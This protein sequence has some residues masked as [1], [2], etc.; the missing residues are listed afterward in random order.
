MAQYWDEKLSHIVNIADLP[1]PELIRAYKAG[2]IYTLIVKDGDELKIGEE[3]YED[4]VFEND[5]AEILATLLTIGDPDG[6]RYLNAFPT[7][8]WT[9]IGY[10]AKWKYPWLWAIYLAK[11][12]NATGAVREH[13]PQIQ[14]L[15][16]EIH[17]QDRC[18][19]TAECSAAPPTLPNP[20]RLIKPRY[21]LE[22]P[23]DS[24]A[25]PPAKEYWAMDNWAALTGLASYKYVCERLSN[26]LRCVDVASGRDERKW[27][28]SEYIDLLDALSTV[29]A[30]TMQ[31]LNLNYLPVDMYFSNASPILYGPGDAN[32]A[33]T[34]SFGHWAWDAY[35]LGVLPQDGV[36]LGMIDPTYISRFQAGGLECDNFGAFN[37]IGYSSAYNAGYGNA[38]LRGEAYRSEGISAYQFMLKNG[39]SGP[40]SWWESFTHATVNNTP[41]IGTHPGG[42]VSPAFSC[43]HITG[44]A[45]ATKVLVDS[46]IALK[47]DGSVIIGRGVPNAWVTQMLTQEKAIK[48]LNFPILN[49]K[50]MGFS[51]TGIPPKQIRLKLEDPNPDG[52]TILDLQALK[53]NI[54][55]VTA[56]TPNPYEGTI[57]LPPGTRTTTVTL[58][59]ANP[60]PMPTP[61][62]I[63][64][65][66]P[67]STIPT[68]MSTFTLPVLTIT[69]DSADDLVGFQGDLTFDPSVVTF[70][71]T[72]VQ[73]AGLTASKWHVSGNVMGTG[74]NR[75]LHIVAYSPK[76]TPLSGSGTLFELRMKRVSNT[77]GASTTLTWAPSARFV[78]K[79]SHSDFRQPASTPR[80]HITI[81]AAN[82]TP[83]PTR[84]ADYADYTDEKGR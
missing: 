68:S 16:H 66:L 57:T 29:H 17:D 33:M 59:T 44:Q 27:A 5:K 14:S 23:S 21:G 55:A 6:L 63:M 61:L 7:S 52:D 40:F 8:D 74:T 56:G 78:F 80:G 12:P 24:A 65:A 39:Q 77:L 13:L 15:T 43:P 35:L 49:G 81:A 1:D 18:L 36:E 84:T 38:A 30:N 47:G 71:S 20:N 54:S 10:Q 82:P 37:S 26:D 34:F 75:T 9:D 72:P 60:T 28:E 50:R 48:V 32:W 69:V 25:P 11:Y 58:T 51:L 3:K 67:I 31:R 42:P 19:T 41:W 79:T 2:Y 46:L 4:E 45:T 83:T 53:N 70:Q 62:A 64:V 22:V 76:G 73:A